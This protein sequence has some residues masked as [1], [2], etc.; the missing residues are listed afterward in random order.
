MATE[1]DLSIL[2]P[3]KTVFEGRVEYV[4]VPGTEGYLGVLA[5]H[6]ALVTGMKAGTLTVREP[7]GK[8]VQYRVDGGFFEVSKNRAT[9]LA[10]SVEAELEV[11]KKR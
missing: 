7:G 1:F 9:V 8:N 11:A 2:T 4:E 10:D 5:H 3:E 6:A